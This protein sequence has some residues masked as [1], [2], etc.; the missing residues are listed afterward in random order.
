MYNEKMMNLQDDYIEIMS[1]CYCINQQTSVRTV[2]TM[3][4][5][6]A[7]VIVFNDGDNEDLLVNVTIRP[8][9]EVMWS[10]TDVTVMYAK[11][12]LREL[13]DRLKKEEKKEEGQEDETV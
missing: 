10:N 8:N 13:F 9:G 4:S 7:S 1:L 2:F 5:T 12:M 11:K 6:S 3:Y